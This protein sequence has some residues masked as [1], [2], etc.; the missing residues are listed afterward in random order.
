MSILSKLQRNAEEARRADPPRAPADFADLT[1]ETE[2]ISEISNAPRHVSDSTQGG[3]TTLSA[4]ARARLTEVVRELTDEAMTFYRGSLP[5][6]ATIPIPQLKTLVRDYLARDDW[7]RAGV[8]EKPEPN[9][10]IQLTGKRRHW[11]V[12]GETVYFPEPRSGAGSAGLATTRCTSMTKK[13]P[14][15]EFRIR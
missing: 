14:S 1:T 10:P 4:D 3:E 8:I 12:D 11:T 7:H 15:N 5:D 13:Q 9:Q 2:Q 6:L